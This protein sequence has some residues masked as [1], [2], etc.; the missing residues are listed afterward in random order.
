MT[1]V[2]AYRIG[3]I[4]TSQCQTSILLIRNKMYFNYIFIFF[5]IQLLM[6]FSGFNSSCSNYYNIILF[7]FGKYYD[8]LCCVCIFFRKIKLLKSNLFLQ[9]KLYA[10]VNR[11]IFLSLVSFLMRVK[12]IYWRWYTHT[13]VWMIYK[14]N[15]TVR[16]TKIRFENSTKFLNSLKLFLSFHSILED[17]LFLLKR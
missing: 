12:S 11:F 6:I 13:I 16:Y 1:T 8:R 7:C 5:S 14:T 4:G 2:T 10:V 17:L 3:N 9:W 15:K